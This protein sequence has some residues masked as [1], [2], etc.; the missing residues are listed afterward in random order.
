MQALMGIIAMQE[1]LMA[2]GMVNPEHIFAA[3]SEMIE[4]SGIEGADRFLINPSKTPI[5]PRQPDPMMVAQ[6]ENLKAQGQAMLTDAQSKMA[7]AQIEAQKAEFEREKAMF[8][9]R[10]RERE[11][12]LKEQEAQFAAMSAAGKAQAEVRHLDADSMLKEAQRLKVL[13]EAKGITIDNQAAE[14]GV[15]DFLKGIDN[16]ASA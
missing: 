1:K 11:A 6:A 8:E 9:A 2:L 16:A 12:S 7:R 10:M 15:M 14:T 3:V 13:G 4:S 5:P